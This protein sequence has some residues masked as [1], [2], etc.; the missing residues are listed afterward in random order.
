MKKIFH[1]FSWSFT[2]LIVGLSVAACTDKETI[3]GLPIGSTGTPENALSF[4]TYMSGSKKETRAGATGNIDTEV[5]KQPEYGFGVFAY[6]TGYTEYGTYRKAG[7]EDKTY[8]NFMYN[9]PVHYNPASLSTIT[10]WEYSPI[11]YW[12]N[13]VT[14][15]GN[16][17]VDDQVDDK[18][19]DPA[20]ASN[21]YGGDVSFFAYAPYVE[22]TQGTQT[23]INGATPDAS[24]IQAD[25]SGI[26]AISGNKYQGVA[27]G[28]D[29]AYYSDPYILFGLPIDYQSKYVDLLWG[30][31]GGTNQNVNNENNTGDT[32]TGA[33]GVWKNSP[34]EY[35]PTLL[36]DYTVNSNLTKQTTTGV[37]DFLFKHAL[38]KV[39]GS[40]QGDDENGDDD[41]KNTP[42]NGLMIVLDLDDEGAE[43]G[44][45]LE[46]FD[47]APNSNTKYKT[48]VT[49]RDI[50]ISAKMLDEDAAGKK[51]G[52][53]GYIP[54]YYTTNEGYLDLATG[55]WILNPVN[56]TTTEPDVA[57]VAQT[58]THNITSDGSATDV[59]NASSGTLSEN[60]AEPASV[61]KTDY[62]F[63]NILPLGVTTVPKNVYEDETN[64]LVF[65]PGT[66]P[67]LTI[68]IDY[69]VRTYDENLGDAFSEVGQKI[70]KTLTFTEVVE[71]NKMYNI[72]IHLG[73]TSV[74]F[75]ASVSDWDTNATTTT[76]TTDDEGNLVNI[77]E[78][79]VDYEVY[80]PR[81]VGNKLE[82]MK[83]NVGANGSIVDGKNDIT[84][85]VVKTVDEAT[86]QLTVL[87]TY[88]NQAVDANTQN[89]SKDIDITK[90]VSYTSDADWVTIDANGLV[91]IA[92]NNTYSK[93]GRSATIKVKYGTEEPE[94]TITVKQYSK[95]IKELTI[96][97]G[98]SAAVT[99][100]TTAASGSY[101]LG[102]NPIGNAAIQATI[103]T[104]DENG[105]VVTTTTEKVGKKA[106]ISDVAVSDGT[107][108]IANQA[109]F[110]ENVLQY[111]ENNS[112][113]SYTYTVTVKYMGKTVNFTFEQAAATPACAAAHFV[114]TNST[115]GSN[116]YTY[117][118][119]ITSNPLSNE[120][121][122]SI[123]RAQANAKTDGTTLDILADISRYLGALYRMDGG[124]TVSSIEYN[125]TTY[126]W[127]DSGTLKGSNWV[128][129]SATPPTL[130]Q[131]LANTPE[132][133]AL[134][135]SSSA[136]TL[137]FNLNGGKSVTIN[138]TI[139]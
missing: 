128:N 132:L 29:P 138:V 84:E 24:E 44:G 18:N 56:A 55:Q 127:N 121:N 7:G 5:L 52:E 139:R 110:S 85:F 102:V 101:T 115:P 2:A 14:T 39:G 95:D 70:T 96:A 78:T 27:A 17:G 16:K 60:I 28:T 93:N 88:V 20:T 43:S 22:V 64:A 49:V 62:A 74:K 83:V 130:V 23:T 134:L 26:N 9:Q 105:T 65:F 123:T 67:Q 109:I 1:F 94:K 125:G 90:N 10:K 35:I 124:T 81:N 116:A 42:T 47:P 89:G 107:N 79:A 82:S 41:D 58:I 36:K 106:V 8:P 19:T 87:G 25:R 57:P 72:L 37:I 86:A 50:Q 104:Y 122:Y 114:Y 11:K 66:Y 46:A 68:T 63:K 119:R 73:L 137:T 113:K 135:S 75:T 91:T 54:T 99:A 12:P 33:Q 103:E 45:E 108:S 133:V 98:L 131:A 100:A 6:Y 117:K 3:D 77:T 69:L 111:K 40:Y 13:E 136:T 38:S 59:K 61:A 80:N 129:T 48:K 97:S 118:G 4:S 120:T 112:S 92:E 32:G 126:T 30:T 71:L 53:E 15:D 31:K 34:T 51:P 21:T 76:T